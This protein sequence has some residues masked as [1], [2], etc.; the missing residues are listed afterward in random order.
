[1]SKNVMGIIFSN[2]NDEMFNELTA[3]E[4]LGA[5]PFGA[6]YRLIDFNLSN[7]HN[8]DISNVGIIAKDHY[9]SLI[10][11]I[12]SGSEWDLSRKKNGLFV[13]PPF[14]QT[15]S[16][17]YK[18][19][20]EALYGITFYLKKS[21]CDY[22]VLS[23]CNVICNMDWRKPLDYHVSKKADITIIYY[24]QE[25]E[26]NNDSETVYSISS[27]GYVN[28]IRMNQKISGTA[29]VDINMW[30]I[31]KNL[32]ISLVEDAMENNYDCIER[33]IFQRRLK[34][35][36]MAAW[37]HQGYIRKLNSISDYFNANLDI[38]NPSIHRD[39]FSRYGNIYTKTT[40]EVPTRYGNFAEVSNSIIGD[41]CIIEGSVENSILFN[42]V[43]IGKEAKVSNCVLMKNCR[44]GDNV[45]LSYVLANKNVSFNNN[46][47]LSGYEKHLY[48]KEGSTI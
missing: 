29:A 17:Y 34:Q 12:G 40:D 14:C 8:S 24:K 9:Q 26:N 21:K 22:V 10:N 5:I 13:F 18:N 16:G 35:Y 23:D 4:T 44:T 33:D 39:L 2:S 41:G 31:S 20:I 42:G 3:F 1:M 32:L 48:I 6:K 47:L 25:N 37:E 28:D 30:I 27:D 46:R 38:L 36:R 7:M 45:N 19:K 43:Y 11:H 15:P